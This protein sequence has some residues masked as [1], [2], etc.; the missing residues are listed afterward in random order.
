MHSTF[1]ASAGAP[2]GAVIHALACPDQ[3]ALLCIFMHAFAPACALAC[4]GVTSIA[5]A[6]PFGHA[7]RV[8]PHHCAACP[9]HCIALAC[10]TNVQPDL[11][12]VAHYAPTLRG[13]LTLVVSLVH[14]AVVGFVHLVGPFPVLSAPGRDQSGQQHTT[15]Q[16]ATR[17]L[18]SSVCP[19]SSGLSGVNVGSLALR[20][21]M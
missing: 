14:C 5:C 13:W 1:Y 7:R 17:L 8:S 21:V 15:R 2:R 4:P 11:S 19:W 3:L 6:P 18:S 16:P 12:Y 10:E 20:F 9:L